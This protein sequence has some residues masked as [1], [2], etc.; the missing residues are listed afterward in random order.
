MMLARHYFY[1]NPMVC[2]VERPI[3]FIDQL[4]VID[5]RYRSSEAT[6]RPVYDPVIRDAPQPTTADPSLK[7]A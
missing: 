6:D 3:A 1:G 7:T 5:R 2:R 4:S